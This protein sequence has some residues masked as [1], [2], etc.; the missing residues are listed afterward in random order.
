MRLGASRGRRYDVAGLREDALRHVPD[1]GLVL[2][3]EDRLAVARGPTRRSGPT[4]SAARRAGGEVHLDGRAA[5]PA[6]ST[7]RSARRPGSRCRRRS[8]GRDRCPRPW[9][10][11]VKNGSKAR[12]DLL[13]HP[14]AGVAD[15]E[16][17]VAAPAGRR[18]GPGEGLVEHGVARSR[19]ASLPPV[20]HRVTGVDGE[21]HE[22]LLDLPRS[23]SI[24]QGPVRLRPRASTRSPSARRSRFSSSATTALRSSTSRRHDLAPAEDQQ[25]ARQG[26]RRAR[27]PAGSPR[28]PRGPGR[29]RGAPRRRTSRS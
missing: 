9:T 12:C 3:H 27:R 4:G 22:H 29:R 5:R 6:P 18:R 10:W 19:R 1:L 21:V 11:C 15:R 20:G 14:D 2:D 13:V 25:L 16:P 17:D 28:R 26:R 23:A 7:G 8:R 24:G